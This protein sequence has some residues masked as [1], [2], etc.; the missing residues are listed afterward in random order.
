MAASLSLLPPPITQILNRKVSLGDTTGDTNVMGAT[1]ANTKGWGLAAGTIQRDP[2]S[3]SRASWTQTGTA[4]TLLVANRPQ[5]QPLS[6]PQLWTQIP[7]PGGTE[8]K[9]CSHSGSHTSRDPN[10][11][12]AEL[13]ASGESQGTYQEL[14]LIREDISQRVVHGPPTQNFLEHNL[15]M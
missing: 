13:S 4:F 7:Q 15:K 2:I 3:I 1:Q 11:E 14:L 10:L 6:L 12:K 5:H 9:A 8:Y